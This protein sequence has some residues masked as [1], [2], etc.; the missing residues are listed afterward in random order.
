MG[1]GGVGG[2]SNWLCAGVLCVLAVAIPVEYRVE[3]FLQLVIYSLA[4]WGWS[5]FAIGLLLCYSK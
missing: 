2:F 1:I 5:G 3:R 4:G